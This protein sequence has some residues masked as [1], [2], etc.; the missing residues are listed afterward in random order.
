MITDTQK[1]QVRFHL[2]YS[3]SVPS[4]DRTILESRLGNLDAYYES[5][6]I[7]ILA[8]CDEA[9]ELTKLT[10]G[11][12]QDSQSTTV[13]GD[14]ARVTVFSQSNSYNLRLRAYHNETNHLAQLLGVF[15]YN[16]SFVVPSIL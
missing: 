15:N 14:I 9:F 1:S 3:L 6:A 16:G 10:E 4:G 2:G 8:R 5:K 7:E 12:P 11:M 13:S